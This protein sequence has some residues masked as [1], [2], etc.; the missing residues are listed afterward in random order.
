MISKSQFNTIQTLNTLLY[1]FIGTKIID[2]VMRRDASRGINFIHPCFLPFHHYSHSLSLFLP[3]RISIIGTETEA[4]FGKA[5][6]R[7][8][9]QRKWEKTK[10]KIE[11]KRK[12]TSK[13]GYHRLDK[14][15]KWCDLFFF[16]LFSFFSIFI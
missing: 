5:A 3:G 13:G 4:S 12:N 1:C 9:S 2:F 14:N 8:N 10:T 16:S 6:G 11:E 7:K 15:H